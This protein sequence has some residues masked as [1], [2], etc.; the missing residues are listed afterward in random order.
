[1]AVPRCHGRLHCRARTGGEVLGAG[2]AGRGRS[3]ESRLCKQ[4]ARELKALDAQFQ[5]HTGCIW[6]LGLPVV[7]FF[8]C[9]FP[10]G[11][12]GCSAGTATTPVELRCVSEQTGSPFDSWARALTRLFG[13]RQASRR[14]ERK[15]GLGMRCEGMRILSASIFFSQLSC[16]RSELLLTVLTLPSS[17]PPGVATSLR[18]PFWRCRSITDWSSWAPINPS[19]GSPTG[20]EGVPGLQRVPAGQM[21]GFGHCRAARACD[22][23]WHAAAVGCRHVGSQRTRGR[24]RTGGAGGIWT[25]SERVERRSNGARYMVSGK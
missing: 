3:G 8:P 2:Q 7:F 15:K 21:R 12:G 10:V 13:W 9:M 4:W 20:G 5:R 16:R 24:G 18:E 19:A 17:P 22:V 14:D 1:M 25:R 11:L 6:P 23:P